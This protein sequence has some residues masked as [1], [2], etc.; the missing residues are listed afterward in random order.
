[1][2]DPRGTLILSAG[3]KEYRLHLGM[4]VLAELQ[5]KHG[6]DVIERL[7]PPDGAGASWLPDMQIVVDLFLLALARHHQ[8][9]ADRWLVDD[10]LAENQDAFATLMA[11]SFP[12]PK[13]D[14]G[15]GKGPR[16][17]A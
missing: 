4:S 12:D 11:T 2:A 17:A 7:Q 14:P 9:E 10:L 3:G 6:Q 8:D 5:A 13:A 1:M 15:N 16:R